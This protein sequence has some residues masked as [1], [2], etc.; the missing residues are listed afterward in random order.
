MTS[1]ATCTLGYSC[2]ISRPE[3]SSVIRVHNY[4][5]NFNQFVAC[6]IAFFTALLPVY[7]AEY[8]SKEWHCGIEVC[9]MYSVQCL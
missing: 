8:I 1:R 6:L 5:T 4:G 2:D 9:H 3:G 7:V